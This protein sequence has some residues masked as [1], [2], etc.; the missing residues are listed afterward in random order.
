MFSFTFLVSLSLS[1][2]AFAAPPPS[3]HIPL[4][5]QLVSSNPAVSSMYSTEP[6]SALLVSMSR[7]SPALRVP[8]EWSFSIGLEWDTFLPP[9]DDHDRFLSY[10]ATLGNGS[11]LPEWMFFDPDTHVFGGFTPEEPQALNIVVT[12]STRFI[13]CHLPLLHC[14]YLLSSGLTASDTFIFIIFSYDFYVYGLLLTRNVTAGQS[15]YI[16]L[17]D[18]QGVHLAAALDIFKHRNEKNSFDIELDL[19]TAALSWLSYDPKS[20][21]LQGTAPNVSTSEELIISATITVYHHGLSLSVLSNFTLAVIP[22]AFSAL[23]LP[24]ILIYPGEVLSFSLLPYLNSVSAWTVSAALPKD[25]CWLSFDPGRLSL[26]GSVPVNA[27]GNVQVAFMAK[28]VDRGLQ[29]ST[30]LTLQVAQHI[31]APHTTTRNRKELL[32]VL[33]IVLG[34]TFLIVSSMRVLTILP[35]T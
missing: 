26:N 19:D 6:S 30:Q 27:S 16:P 20:R 11:D 33:G 21:V 7:S 12:A 35:L 2:L 24:S 1:T 25:A 13:L 3:L 34:I 23:V 14:L 29:S 15:F 17:S 22:P 4:P 31:S 8:P 28:D 18:F 9:A 5:S 10:S 32:I